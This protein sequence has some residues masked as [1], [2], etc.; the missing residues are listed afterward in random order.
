MEDDVLPDDLVV[1]GNDS[2]H[3][4]PEV[5]QE[6]DRISRLIA[7]VYT[8]DVSQNETNLETFTRLTN[9]N[10]WLPFTERN[11]DISREERRL[12]HEMAQHYS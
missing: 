1:A 9:N 7:A 11:D 4:S 3:D 10:P 2:S 8:P 12:F 5:A 6:A